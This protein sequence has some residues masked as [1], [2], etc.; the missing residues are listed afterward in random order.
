MLRLRPLAGD[1]PGDVLKRP[2]PVAEAG[3]ERPVPLG[4]FTPQAQ[5]LGEPLL[6]RVEQSQREGAFREEALHGVQR[7]EGEVRVGQWG[8]DTVSLA[9]EGHVLLPG[10]PGRIP[11]HSPGPAALE[12]S[13]SVHE[14]IDLDTQGETLHDHLAQGAGPAV[15]LPECLMVG[16]LVRSEEHEQPARPRRFR[17]DD[18]DGEGAQQ[19]DHRG[20]QPGGRRFRQHVDLHAWFG[21]GGS[22]PE[23]LQEAEGGEA[24]GDGAGAG[25]DDVQ[26]ALPVGGFGATSGVGVQAGSRGEGRGAVVRRVGVQETAQLGDQVGGDG[27]SVTERCEGGQHVPLGEVR[28]VEA[29]RGDLG[30]RVQ[31][32]QQPLGVREAVGVLGAEADGFLADGVV[33]G[34]CG[35]D[36]QQMPARFDPHPVPPVQVALP[37]V[38]ESSP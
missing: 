34:H 28:L 24:E 29:E 35:P 23:D 20:G 15:E 1:A 25:A 12:E 17:V 18:V 14:L 32:A 22:L 10:D 4:E 38:R 6:D 9:G 13:V 36:V 8:G 31:Q 3:G 5:S 37:C 19:A 30:R 21:R 2:A 27:P 33:A 16:S 7:D 26:R 11:Y